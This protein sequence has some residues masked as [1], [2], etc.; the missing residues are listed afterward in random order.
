MHLSNSFAHSLFLVL[1]FLFFLLCIVGVAVSKHSTT[2]RFNFAAISI[3]KN[4]NS[5]HSNRLGHILLLRLSCEQRVSER[6]REYTLSQLAIKSRKYCIGPTKL[7]SMVETAFHLTENNIVTRFL[8]L[9]NTFHHSH[10]YAPFFVV[11][12]TAAVSFV[13]VLIVG[14]VAVVDVNIH[15][16]V[17]TFVCV[18]NIQL[19]LFTNIYSMK[20]CCWHVLNSTTYVNTGWKSEW[21]DERE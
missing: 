17:A 21:V 14:V 1:F 8:W 18:F 16:V 13:V 4:L 9:G 3:Y 19:S 6:E 10:V 5:S 11:F 20:I 2:T 15:V 12:V 7:F